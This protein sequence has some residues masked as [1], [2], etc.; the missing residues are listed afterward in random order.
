MKVLKKLAGFCKHYLKKL[1]NHQIFNIVCLVGFGFLCSKEN[2]MRRV[3][4]FE[5]IS[6]IEFQ[7]FFQYI[8]KPRKKRKAVLMIDIFP[9]GADMQVVCIRRTIQY[10][11]VDCNQTGHWKE[12][13]IMIENFKS[14]KTLDYLL[15]YHTYPLNDIH[16]TFIKDGLIS[17]CI[18]TVG[19]V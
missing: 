11:L 9:A 19:T 5:S 6:Q 1:Y 13:K 2:P 14:L 7:S 8:R 4:M 12:K 18:I 3:D 16:N 10:L 15:G 17:E